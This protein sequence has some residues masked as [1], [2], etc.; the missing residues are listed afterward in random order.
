M[1]YRHG[2]LLIKQVSQFAG[3]RVVKK[4]L[5][6]EYEVVLLYGEATGH[7]HRLKSNKRI[8]VYDNE[9]QERFF[10]VEGESYL[11]HEEHDRIDLPPGKYA[12][13]RQ[14]VYTPKEIKYV[15]D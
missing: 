7:A 1:K 13:I 4:Y 12:V 8:F 14:R 2:D 5:D 15:V 9:A 10:E 3:K 6:D 11:S